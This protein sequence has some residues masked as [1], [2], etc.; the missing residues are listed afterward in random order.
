MTGISSLDPRDSKKILR[1]ARERQFDEMRVKELVDF[2]F[3]EYI[4]QP[5]NIDDLIVGVLE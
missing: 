4:G 2:W 1:Q 3:K 5:E